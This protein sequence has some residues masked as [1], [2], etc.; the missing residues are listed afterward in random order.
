MQNLNFAANP[1]KPLAKP[2]N[3]ARES[4]LSALIAAAMI[5]GT[6]CADFAC[7]P[8]P[9]RADSEA[10]SE[11]GSEANFYPRRR[12]RYRNQQNQQQQR[13]TNQELA[14]EARERNQQQKREQRQLSHGPQ[15]KEYGA[16]RHHQQQ[17]QGLGQQGQGQQAQ[18][19][20][21]QTNQRP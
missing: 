9:V 15:I 2:V 18:I 13:T 3:R 6:A 11:A 1:V 20:P 16:G 17:Q 21:G 19:Q 4:S 7:T 14:R 8:L 10:G 12:G 5:I